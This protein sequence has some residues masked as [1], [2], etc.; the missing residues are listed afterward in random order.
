MRVGFIGL[1]MM[2]K[3]MAANLQKAGHDLVVHD[4]SRAAAE[5]LL[6]K[7]AVWA[8]SP[9]EVG[10]QS[11][12]VFTSLPV[13]GDVE[14]VALGTNGLIEGMR[15]D[16]ALFDMS[17][18]SV[19]TVRKI[20]AAFAEKNLYMLDSPVSGGPSGAASGKMA[21]WVGGDEQIFN[22]HKPVL[23]AMGDQ[24]AYIGPIGAGSIAKLV[25]NCTSAVLGLALAEVFTMGVKAG[26][27]P[28]DLWEAVRQGATGR[29][30]TFDRL[31]DRFLTGQHDPAD[32]ALRLLHKDVG[33]AVGLGREVGVPMRLANMAYEELT[34]AMNRGW[35]TRNS[36]VGQL[37]QVERA[38]I[39]PL[40]A[41]P[42]RIAAVRDADKPK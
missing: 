18:N 34:E 42:Q 3:G 40:A 25:H 17:T 15:P 19:A 32:F 31:G 23:D 1:G 7:G 24:A 9:R 5:P 10:A 27:D 22:R 35:G 36:T 26:V 29:V 16:T 41:D 11:E 38:G 39:P 30:R 33:L 14:T 28:V 4:L 2:G 12:I 8:N 20:H 21:I 13:P 37:L 6:A